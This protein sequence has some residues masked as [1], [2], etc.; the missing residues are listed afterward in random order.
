M[1]PDSLAQTLIAARDPRNP[2]AELPGPLAPQDLADAYHVQDCVVAALGCQT[3]GYKVAATSRIAQEHLGIDGPFTGRLLAERVYRSPASLPAAE[4]R[5]FVVEPEYA[6]T[7]GKD[8]PLR[9]EAY[10]EAEVSSAV[11][12][13]HPAFEIVSSAYDAAWREA[14]AAAL[15]ADNAV[16]TAMIM[17]P[18]TSDW[19][20]LD[21]RRRKVRLDVDG[22]LHSEGE[23]IRA[24][25]GPLETLLWLTRHLAER[26]LGLKAGDVVTTGVVTDIAYLEAGQRAFADF[27]EL[28]TVSFEVK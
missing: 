12:S 23:G 24:L 4:H 7:L 18:A 17:G 25:G 14:G 20:A 9:E 27:G 22:V 15:I 6:F 28:G 13:L 11:A 2:P 26:N 3:S 8:L 10:S 19:R 16:H 1:Q 21:F 5:F